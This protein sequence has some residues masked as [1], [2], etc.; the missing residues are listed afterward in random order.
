MKLIRSSLLLLLKLLVLAIGVLGLS[1][2]NAHAQAA[3]NGTFALTHGTRWGGVLLPPCQYAFSLQSPGLPS[4]IV[5]RRAGSSQLAIVMPQTVT[6]DKL[7][8]NS[9]LVLHSHEG[10]ESFV[11][12]LYL[13]DLGLALYYA[14]PRMQVAAAQTAKLGPMPDSQ[15]S[16]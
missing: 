12:A 8:R 11:S 10:G 14:P 2:T 1:A 3:A 5:L 4:Q 6:S 9:R 16:K 7:T 13:G 15:P